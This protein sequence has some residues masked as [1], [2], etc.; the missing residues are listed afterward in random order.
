MP[1]KILHTEWPEGGGGQA[2]RIV[3]ESLALMKKGYR[4]R[5][6]C[7]PGSGIMRH[8][9][10]AGIPTVE[11]PMRKGLSLAAVRR[12][13]RAID[14]YGIDIVHAHSSEDAQ[15][16]E[17]IIAWIHD[18]PAE[19]RDMAEKGYAHCLEH[20]TFEKMIDTTEAAY[21]FALCRSGK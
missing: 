12:T 18:H 16:L 4:M 20:F 14:E 17:E 2:I 3:A 13:M 8:A 19:S 10:E 6:A 7:Q 21:R 11:I 1:L 15:T 5:I 9:Q